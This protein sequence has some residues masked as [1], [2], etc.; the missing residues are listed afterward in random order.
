MESRTIGIVGASG[1]VGAALAQELAGLPGTRLRLGAREPHH[2]SAARLEMSE[3]EFE[4]CPVDAFDVDSLTAFC[5]DCE[6]V[7]NCAGPSCEVL[8]RVAHAA[9]CNGADYVDVAG[10]EPV[11]ERLMPESPWLDG[12]GRRVVLSAGMMPGLTG[13]L[14]RN[15]ARRRVQRPRRLTAYC[16]GLQRFTPAAARDFLSSLENGHGESGALWRDGRRVSRA[17]SALS[18]VELPLFPARSDAHP[19]LS[20]EMERLAEALQLDELSSFNV[21]PAERVLRVLAQWQAREPDGSLTLDDARDGLVRASELDLAGLSPYQ[22][23]FFEMAG[24][25]EGQSVSV[26]LGVHARDGYRLTALAASL[27]VTEILDGQLPC[28]LSY[29]AEAL[30]P[31][32]ADVA[33]RRSPVVTEYRFLDGEP[34]ASDWFEEGV[35]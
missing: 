35:C 19:F 6:V 12:E 34:A 27:A 29:F 23:M 14:P 9:L 5:R 7:V 33:L 13:L 15:L 4:R 25:H 30:T 1:A 8:D 10:D 2:L 21:F 31:G 26:G 22:V 20:A 16:G 32:R 11:Y 3:C 18:D 24:E 28:G 17:A